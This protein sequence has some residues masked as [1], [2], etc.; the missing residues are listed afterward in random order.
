M[1]PSHHFTDICCLI[2]L[3]TYQAYGDDFWVMLSKTG[4][5]NLWVCWWENDDQTLDFWRPQNRN[6]HQ[7][8]PVTL[9]IVKILGV[10]FR[11]TNARD[12]RRWFGWF[13]LLFPINMNIHKIP[14][15]QT[16]GPSDGWDAISWNLDKIQFIVGF[17]ILASHPRSS[18]S[19]CW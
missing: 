16:T 11:E 19:P 6:Y 10:S 2:Q 3:V 8:H 13:G 18:L 7:W 15:F 12:D 1:A 14:W 9:S 17:L 5:T 4:C